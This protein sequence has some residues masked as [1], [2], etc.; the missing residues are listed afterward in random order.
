MT[1]NNNNKGYKQ[2]ID[3]LTALDEKISTQ[4]FYKV[5]VTKYVDIETGRAPYMESITKNRL[6]SIGNTS[7]WFSRDSGGENL[8]TK[9]TDIEQDTI[10][11][12]RFLGQMLIT[13]NW[14][15]L[16]KLSVSQNYDAIAEKLKARKVSA[17]QLFQEV[18]F[19]GNKANANSKG[20]LN[21]DGITVNT[22]AITKPISEMDAEEIR[23]FGSDLVSIFRINCGKSA[24]PNIF[25]MPEADF[26]GM[27][28]SNDPIFQ[29]YTRFEYLLKCFDDATRE[30][31]RTGDFK[32]LPN[33]YSDIDVNP[34][35][36]GKYELYNKDPDTIVYDNPVP[37][38]VETFIT[39]DNMNWTSA[40]HLQIGE[41]RLYKPKEF[42]QF[43]NLNAIK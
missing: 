7:D 25:L 18:A 17:D 15:D 37:F 16:R 1:Y 27:S 5:D 19:N 42:I 22:T 8:E 11:N 24:V 12:F 4:K 34:L 30:L 36:K 38:T 41:V 33:A 14:L 13:Y 3:T 40:A 29:R 28:A 10:T 43:I 32:I 26:I 6:Y 9:K 2:V 21:L 31:G 23:T 35:N 20:L 39:A